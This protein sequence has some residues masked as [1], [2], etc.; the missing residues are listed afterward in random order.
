MTEY[1]KLLDDASLNNITVIENYDLSC[2]R[3]KGL[4][5]DGVIALNKNIETDAEKRCV[6]VEE[7]GH[8]YTASGNILDQSSTS[9]RKQEFHGRIMAYN[10]LIGLIGIINSFKNHCQ[11]IAESAEYLDVTEEFLNDA[12]SYYKSKYG[13]SVTV[14]NYV[15]YFE[16]SLGVLELV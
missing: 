5:C 3:I 13:V 7:L 14:D 1:E 15:I 12:L 2:T 4:Y 9:N 8:H 16:P 11:S 10:R 6:L